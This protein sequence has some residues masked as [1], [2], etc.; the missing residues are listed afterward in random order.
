MRPTLTSTATSTAILRTVRSVLGEDS[1]PSGYVT[2]CE[3]NVVDGL[4]MVFDS[5]RGRFYAWATFDQAKRMIVI[6]KTEPAAHV[7]GS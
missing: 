1:V 2:T 7:S 6:S 5:A 3:P 4:A